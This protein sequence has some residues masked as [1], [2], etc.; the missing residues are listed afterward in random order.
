[1]IERKYD[2]KD[3]T[4]T[5]AI[6]TI[7]FIKHL[8]KDTSGFTISDQLARSSTSIGANIEEADGASTRN[9][10]FYKM[11]LARKEARETRY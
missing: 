9:D 2:L 6:K 1:M 4:L 11:S 3:R 8:P 5:F 7:K 10:M